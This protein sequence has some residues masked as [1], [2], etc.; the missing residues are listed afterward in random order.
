MG[1]RIIKTEEFWDDLD[2]HVVDDVRTV[3][4]ALNDQQYSIDLGPENRQRL[5][6][7]LAEFIAKAT[8]GGATASRPS[9]TS[10]GTRRTRR[11]SEE[12]AAE[13]EQKA[14][15]KAELDK[16]R[17]WAKKN[18]YSVGEKG[19]IAQNILDEYKKANG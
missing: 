1:K 7:A 15:H 9:A 12:V 18:G 8:T 3:R 5:A 6:D 2:A 16:I 11:S 13:K 17:A 10:S 4:F 14:K 19:R